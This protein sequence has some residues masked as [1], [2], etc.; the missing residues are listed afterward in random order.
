MNGRLRLA[1]SL[2]AVVLGACSSGSPDP[3]AAATGLQDVV[4]YGQLE[5]E[6]VD[7]D[8]T[9]EQNPP[10]G[11]PHSP[12]W[13][14]CGFYDT[15]IRDEH[16]VHSMEHGAVWITYDPALDAEAVAVIE[17]L[18]ADEGYVLASP[19][20]GL[21]SRVV[22]SAWGAQLLLPS[23]TDP[24]LESFVDTYAESPQAPEPGAPCSGGISEA[25]F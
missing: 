4:E 23:T 25:G 16:A 22:A 8:V 7:G 20:A 15:P 9:Y 10:V 14:D 11:G 5:G 17:Q 2:L 3:G 1:A 24:R 13:Q 19:R 12:A 18:A 21:P 6:H